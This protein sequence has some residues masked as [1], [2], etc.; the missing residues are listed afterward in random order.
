MKLKKLVKEEYL[1]MAHQGPFHAHTRYGILLWKH[2]AASGRVLLLQKRAIRI[3]C[4]IQP[5]DYCRPLFARSKLMTV[6][7][8]F[9]L[10]RLIDVETNLSIASRVKF[11]DESFVVAVTSTATG[12]GLRNPQEGFLNRQFVH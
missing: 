12:V 1:V 2:A 11:I 10:D 4:R 5:R 7:N 9:I 6:Y 8:H 3:V